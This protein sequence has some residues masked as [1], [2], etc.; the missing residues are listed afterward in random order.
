MD[1]SKFWLT[2]GT[3]GAMATIA[4]GFN[5]T[6]A[7]LSSVAHE[8][9]LA[10]S[11]AGLLV[12]I[13]RIATV[14]TAP[15]GG[16][17]TDRFGGERVALIAMTTVAGGMAWFGLCSSFASAIA[18]MLV[19]GIGFGFALGFV[20]PFIS[21]LY[22]RQVGLMLN[23]CNAAFSGAAVLAGAAGGYIIQS[24]GE[25]RIL[26]LGIAAMGC[27]VMLPFI[28]RQPRVAKG[29]PVRL[30]LVPGILRHR[31]FIPL[32]AMK[33]LS[34]GVETSIA[35]WLC[36]YL[37]RA[38]AFQPASAGA[39]LS[40]F[41]IGMTIGRLITGA[42]SSQ[43]NTALLLALCGV[44]VFIPWSLAVTLKAGWVVGLL[45]AIAGLL[46]GGTNALILTYAR[47]HFLDAF[48]TASGMLTAIGSIGG[49][50]LAY[51]VGVAAERLSITTSLLFIGLAALVMGI[52]A[53]GLWLHERP[54]SA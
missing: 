5:V 32:S 27:C 20:V 8:F 38:C 21:S 51:L 14:F 23:V 53:F 16:F 37:E 29:Q 25:W 44:G 40:L 13:F 36:F 43:M 42:M 24:F 47:P 45:V 15:I 50:V 30:S 54:G 6:G 17:L 52:I 2:F 46:Q 35:A 41:W 22:P 49:F 39:V 1:K 31:L 7:A 18:A 4:S 9:G 33:A 26:Y 48:G 12:S 28:G 10:V 3:L 34:F 19:F 11:K